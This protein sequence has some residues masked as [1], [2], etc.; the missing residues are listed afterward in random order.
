MSGFVVACVL[1]SGGDYAVDYVEHLQAGL[2]EH[3][4]SA[5]L[6]CLSDCAVPCE[7]IPLIHDWPHWWP[8]IELFRPGLFSGPVLYLD[9]DTLIV[10]DLSPLMEH[11]HRFTALTDF[12]T[13]ARGIGSGVMAWNGDYSHI[14][15]RFS[16]DPEGWQA[17]CRNGR[18]AWGDQGFI[19]QQV[20]ADRWQDI[21]PN[22]IQSAKVRGPRGRARII[23]FH[24]KPRP[25][26]VG[27]RLAS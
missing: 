23:C 9:L 6:V 5:R 19:G 20:K 8:K 16:E 17:R 18:N 21:Y 22:A 12:L 1:R 3:T 11:P 26:D 10:G 14:Y 4:P 24:G 13:P 27:W 2:A 7:R 25:R 15:H